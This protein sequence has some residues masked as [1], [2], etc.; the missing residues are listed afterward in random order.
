MYHVITGNGKGKTTAAIGMSVRAAGAGLKVFIAQFV[1][2]KH[3]AEHNTLKL[4]PNIDFE[5][6]GRTCFIE[7]EPEQADY[8]IAQAGW[9]KVKER[10]LQGNI[11]LLILDEL[12]IA[13][14]YKLI[15]YSDV[16][17]FIKQNKNQLEIVS[18]GR[19]AV[20]G[21]MDM[22]DLVSEVN[23]VKHYYN[24]GLEAREGIEY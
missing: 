7:N 2:G 17:R 8:D 24:N 1:K 22:A 15:N 19:Y 13:L 21:L 20:Q 10:V 12:H 5:L 23:E 9:R 16:V 18:T 14:Y 11:D 4:I 3:Y 6:M